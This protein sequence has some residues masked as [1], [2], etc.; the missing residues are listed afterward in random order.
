MGFGV[1]VYVS[2]SLCVSLCF[3]VRLCVCVFQG[4]QASS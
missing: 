2:V 4:D 1:C 3:C